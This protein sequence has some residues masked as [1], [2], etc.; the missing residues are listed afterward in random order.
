VLMAI[1]LD[2]ITQAMAGEGRPSRLKVVER[3][4]EA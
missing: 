1:V 2:R 4:A 3:P